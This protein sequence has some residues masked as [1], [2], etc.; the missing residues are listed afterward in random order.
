MIQAASRRGVANRFDAAHHEANL[1]TM[2]IKVACPHKRG[3]S[4]G[5]VPANP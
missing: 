3:Q 4:L 2:C 5:C 1:S